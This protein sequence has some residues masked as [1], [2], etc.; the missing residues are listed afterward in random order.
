MGLWAYGYTHENSMSRPIPMGKKK[1]N[2]PLMG[3]IIELDDG[4]ILATESL[5]DM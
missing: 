2:S 3:T 1:E 4:K 5:I